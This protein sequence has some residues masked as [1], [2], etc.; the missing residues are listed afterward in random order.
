MQSVT[1]ALFGTTTILSFP[2]FRPVLS[3]GLLIYC[4]PVVDPSL[5]DYKHILV[6]AHPDLTIACSVF[7]LLALIY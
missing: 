2:T 3:F 5:F 7:L 6:F 4:L 1:E